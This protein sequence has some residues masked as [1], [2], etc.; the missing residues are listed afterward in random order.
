[1]NCCNLQ[2]VHMISL[3]VIGVLLHEGQSKKKDILKA[4]VQLIERENKKLDSESCNLKSITD[5]SIAKLRLHNKNTQVMICLIKLLSTDPEKGWAWSE[6]GHQYNIGKE[7]SKATTCFKQAAKLNGKLSKFIDKWYFIGPFVIGKGEVDGD[8]LQWYGG[9]VNAS[10]E[11]YNRK[12]TTYYSELVTGGEIHW[13]TIEQKSANDRLQIMPNDVPW[14][15]LVSSLGSFAITE[16]QGWLVG[17]FS[18][19]GKDEDVL[20]QCLGIHTIFIDGQFIA[21]DV[22]RRDQFWYGISLAPGIHT[23]YIRLR[24]KGPQILQCNLKL[25]GSSK[26]DVHPPSMIPHLVDGHVVGSVLAIPITNLQ[27]NKWLKNVR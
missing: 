7:K 16:W 11:R 23:V 20:I 17:E 2:F 18:V 13:K 26:Y 5:A 15:E 4:S 12:K 8:P 3:L 9:I 27:T 21:A 22:Y 10:K 25:A 6:L 14:N 19:N 1:M 24:S